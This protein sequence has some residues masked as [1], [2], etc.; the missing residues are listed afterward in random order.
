MAWVPCDSVA[1]R[2]P[3]ALAEARR[4]TPSGSL[5][6]IANGSAGAG[7]VTA[8]ADFGTGSDAGQ[9]VGEACGSMLLE[10]DG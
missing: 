1:T 3:D 10:A 8:V 5:T 6:Q 9:D 2:A 4:L 7:D